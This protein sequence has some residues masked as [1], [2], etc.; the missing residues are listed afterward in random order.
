M[1]QIYIASLRPKHFKYKSKYIIS[2]YVHRINAMFSCSFLTDVPVTLQLMAT[3]QKHPKTN[4]N[5][6]FGKC[7]ENVCITPTFVKHF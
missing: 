3:H 4:Q 1:K 5:V 7:V 6:A 2:I